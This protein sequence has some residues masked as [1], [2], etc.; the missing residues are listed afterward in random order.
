MKKL[1]G[2]ALM[3]F[4]LL[5][6]CTAPEGQYGE[7]AGDGKIRILVSILPQKE[8]VKSVGGDYVDVKE[9]VPPGASP[10]TY[11]LKPADLIA[12]EN[13]GIYFRIGHIPFE[14]AYIG[15][16]ESANPD[17]E[18]VDT[19]KNAELI[20]FGGGSGE[21]HSHDEGRADP[22]I[23]L[24]PRRVAQQVEIIYKTLAEKDP[25]HEDYYRQNADEYI[26][27]LKKLDEGLNKTFE[28][29]EGKKVLVFH[30]AWGYFC[31]DY[32]LEQIAIEPE[33]KEPTAKQLKNIIDIAKSEDIKVVFVQKQFSTTAAS[34]V[35]DEIGGVV[36]HID[37]LAENYLESMQ[38]VGEAISAGLENRE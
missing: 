1:I 22:H 7:A 19:S 2:I 13:A 30:P 15:K 34:S 37:P 21:A 6:G 11:E 31:H 23:W 4:I 16:I 3:L 20:Y 10:A 38:N 9:L 5:F 25:E 8:F 26:E 35:A 28:S 18:V 29:M 12:I 33:G 14:K 32:G 24:S 17:L 36:V 27:K